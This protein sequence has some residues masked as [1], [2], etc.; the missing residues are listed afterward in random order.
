MNLSSSCRT[1]HPSG[2]TGVVSVENAVIIAT[3]A[4][5]LGIVTWGL[6]GD[7]AHSLNLSSTSIEKSL[8]PESSGIG[9]K[10]QGRPALYFMAS[11]AAE[12]RKSSWLPVAIGSLGFL[13]AVAVAVFRRRKAKSLAKNDEPIECVRKKL[14]PKLTPGCVFTKR[15]QTMAILL[16]RLGDEAFDQMK[17]GHL[18][19]H[20]VKS[21]TP[22]APLEE[23]RRWFFTHH[24]RHVLVVDSQGKLKGIISARDLHRADTGTAA[25]IMTTNLVTVTPQQLIGPTITQMMDRRIS[26]L[27]VVENGT[28]IGMV[29]TTDLLIALQCTLQILQSL[30]SLVTADSKKPQTLR[31]RFFGNPS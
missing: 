2:R 16:N 29:T 28:L 11:S 23:V 5:A 25:D 24:F 26:C 22:D 1:G 8:C 18:L 15:Q 4:G 7:A 9:S 6:G 3:I 20:N 21:L 14:E 19:T 31:D 13:G 30:G 27:P 17:I 12:I 10:G